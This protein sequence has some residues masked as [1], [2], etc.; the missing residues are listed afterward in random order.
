MQSASQ[1]SWATTMLQGRNDAFLAAFARTA[2]L[3]GLLPPV[4]EREG[5]AKLMNGVPGNV[6][7]YRLQD[8]RVNVG[9]EQ[10]FIHQ[11]LAA[12]AAPP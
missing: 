2:D 10:S 12:T 9:V 5:V 4:D 7:V 11:G 3:W 8:F 6:L 1:S